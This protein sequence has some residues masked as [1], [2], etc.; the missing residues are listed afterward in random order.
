LLY[1]SSQRPDTGFDAFFSEPSKEVGIVGFE[2]FVEELRDFLVGE[3]VVEWSSGEDID[4]RDVAVGYASLED[5][6]TD[7]PC[8]ACEDYLHGE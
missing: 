2:V 3:A 6:A 5:L 8:A 4:V 1:G 7:E